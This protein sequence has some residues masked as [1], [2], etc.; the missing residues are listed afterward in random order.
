MLAAAQPAQTGWAGPQSPN[1]ARVETGRPL[2]SPHRSRY[3]IIA[4]GLQQNADFRIVG[5]TQRCDPTAK[6]PT[7]SSTPV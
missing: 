5:K 4:A 3:V 7:T 6:S 2:L 1:P